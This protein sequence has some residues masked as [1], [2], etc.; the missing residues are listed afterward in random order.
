MEVCSNS[1]SLS[2]YKHGKNKQNQFQYA[3]FNSCQRQI[4][5][6]PPDSAPAPIIVRSVTD[7]AKQLT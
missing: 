7:S 3:E 2:T 1:A 5:A 4:N 6:H